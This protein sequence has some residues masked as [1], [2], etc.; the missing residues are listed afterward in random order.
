MT[1]ANFHDPELTELL[2]YLKYQEP[3]GIQ[4][5]DSGNLPDQRATGSNQEMPAGTIRI[6]LRSLDARNSPSK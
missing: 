5:C 3:V 1:F 4:I 2:T 6:V